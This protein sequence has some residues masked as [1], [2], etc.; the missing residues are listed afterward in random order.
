MLFIWNIAV[1]QYRT[2]RRSCLLAFRICMVA[3]RDHYGRDGT[4]DGTKDH[5]GR[6]I[7]SYPL[8]PMQMPK[9]FG[10]KDKYGKVRGSRSLAAIQLSNASGGRISLWDI[11]P[12]LAVCGN[13]NVRGIWGHRSLKQFFGCQTRFWNGLSRPYPSSNGA[14]IY[15]NY[16]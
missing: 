4:K 5:Y 7:R 13:I 6:V 2:F 10:A 3:S 1:D 12:H 8:T 16:G 15:N 9:A 11:Q 14:S